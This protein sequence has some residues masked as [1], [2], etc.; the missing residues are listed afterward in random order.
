M[1]TLYD[2]IKE[3]CEERGISPSAFGMELTG[4]K[5]FMTELKM[6]RKKGISARTAQ[7]IADYFGVSADRVLFGK[8]GSVG[9]CLDKIQSR[10]ELMTLISATD[11]L[12]KEQVLLLAD[13][14]K[15]IR[16]DAN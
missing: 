11:G 9:E 16:G 6:G 15:S 13:C 8:R 1:A 7:R 5:A 12:T 3:L 2:N 4:S 14:V 10:P